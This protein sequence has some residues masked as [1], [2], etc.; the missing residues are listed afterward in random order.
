MP[1]LA[2]V[3][4]IASLVF[5]FQTGKEL[6]QTVNAAGS[7]NFAGTDVSVAHAGTLVRCFDAV[8]AGTNSR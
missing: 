8:A 5:I 3:W 4:S 1:R 7:L 6:L 2:A